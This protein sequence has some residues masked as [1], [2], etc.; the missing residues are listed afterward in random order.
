MAYSPLN[1]KRSALVDAKAPLKYDSI[2]EALSASLASNNFAPKALKGSHEFFPFMPLPRYGDIT[3][4]L[5]VFHL[6]LPGEGGMSI[7]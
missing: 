1:F 5:A 4:P 6:P 7:C 2:L 3:T